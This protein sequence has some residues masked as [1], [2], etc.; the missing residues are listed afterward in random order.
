MTQEYSELVGMIDSHDVISFDVFDTLLLRPFMDPNMLFQFIEQTTGTVGFA[1]QR[2]K[3]EKT[4]EASHGESSLDTI[5]QKIPDY[6]HLQAIE[7]KA[8]L[9]LT[10]RNEKMI[11]A[12][13]YAM[14]QSKT[15]II[16]SDTYFSA[17]FMAQLLE[18]NGI[19][20]Y[21]NIFIS[22]DYH[23][24]KHSGTLFEPVI[25]KYGGASL[26]HV[27]DN[28]ISDFSMPRKHG[29]DA[30]CVKRYQ[31]KYLANNSFRIKNIN[32]WQGSF[33]AM[34]CAMRE[35]ISFDN[36]WHKLGFQLVGPLCYAYTSW[37]ISQL[38]QLMQAKKSELEVCF[39][40]RDGY[41]LKKCF[42]L[43]TGKSSKY[44]YAPRNVYQAV[45]EGNTTTTSAKAISE[46][47]EYILKE[48]TPPQIVLIDTRTRNYSSQNLIEKMI[49]N[50]IFGLYYAIGSCNPELEYRSYNPSLSNS[51]IAWNLV[52]YLL[53]SP[54]P[55]VIGVLNSEPVF[56][57]KDS[58]EELRERNFT[59]IEQGMIEFIEQ[60]L[61]RFS[62]PI[63]I[64]ESIIADWI[65][66][67]IQHPKKEDLDAFKNVT[68]AG[69][70][71]HENYVKLN[72][73]MPAPKSVADCKEL[74]RR[75]LTLHPVCYA[76]VKKIYNIV[77][78]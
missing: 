20:G 41:L 63:E 24:T 52:E 16:V 73:F 15:V 12:L 30:F 58:V 33:F 23:K 37:L 49:G 4:A 78:K 21:S 67:F 10:F 29:I 27:G 14:D 40:S 55:S 66:E 47:K 61:K 65:N 13:Q 50:K 3:A 54:T 28:P 57:S 7:E 43:M 74:F 77:H 64:P 35:S 75:K 72:V 71:K 38:E 45:L 44:I 5:Y 18:K 31:D 69:D 36:Y 76:C 19:T 59:F 46:Y 60:A 39:V 68:F 9:K 42:E 56:A 48:I 26:M 17:Q 6:S 32:T 34:T 53:S 1:K 22:S 2:S 11:Q 25:E 70:P 51:I 62:T 8:E